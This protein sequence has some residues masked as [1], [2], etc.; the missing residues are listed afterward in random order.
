MTYSS[1]G[2]GNANHL[3]GVLFSDATGLPMEHVP[4]RGGSEVARDLAAGTQ[5]MLGLAQRA[6][7]AGPEGAA[8]RICEAS[9]RTGGQDD[10]SVVVIWRPVPESSE[11]RHARGTASV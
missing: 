9:A 6:I 11:S 3:A 7:S 8:Q 4:Y 5:Q 2:V 10:R 1:G